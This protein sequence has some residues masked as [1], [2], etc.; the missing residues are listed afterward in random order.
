MILG[1]HRRFLRLVQ[2]KI[3][4]KRGMLEAIQIA[5]GTQTIRDDP[6]IGNG[7]WDSGLTG[8]LS[9]NLRTAGKVARC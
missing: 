4:M 1:G 3:R 9:N 2:I 6:G 7:V 5:I 8:S